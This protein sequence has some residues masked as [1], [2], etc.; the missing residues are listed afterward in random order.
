M[1]ECLCL[2]SVLVFLDLPNKVVIHIL[3]ELTDV[4]ISHIAS[5]KASEPS[6]SRA[7]ILMIPVGCHLHLSIELI[8]KHAPL[9]LVALVLQ[10]LIECSSVLI[11]V[12]QHVEHLA[13]HPTA[14][15]LPVTYV[16]TLDNMLAYL[17]YCCIVHINRDS[18]T[19]LDL[20]KLVVT[21][22][23]ILA[24][25]NACCLK[26]FE[27]HLR[28]G[29]LG[30]CCSLYVLCYDVQV[31]TSDCYNLLHNSNYF[32]WLLKIY[33]TLVDEAYA[34]PLF[35]SIQSLRIIRSLSFFEHQNHVPHEL[36]HQRFPLSSWTSTY[37]S[38]LHLATSRRSPYIIS[39]SESSFS[40]KALK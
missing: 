39:S 20:D 33:L 10:H 40:V 13:H 9:I 14:E 37:S 21:E 26:S 22:R 36:S 29:L 1:L 30:S 23:E 11:H 16:S 19:I 2:L 25:V 15:Q 18:R 8:F 32:N 12:S 6:V 3:S 34:P 28:L 31:L 4:V 24:H 35:G 27:T 38:S 7:C 5:D 17:I